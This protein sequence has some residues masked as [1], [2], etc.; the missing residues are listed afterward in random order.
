MTN[1]VF[2]WPNF[3]RITSVSV[4]FEKRFFKQLTVNDF[5]SVFSSPV[6]KIPGLNFPLSGSGI[7]FSKLFKRHLSKPIKWVLKVSISLTLNIQI[8]C[9]LGFCSYFLQ[10]NLQKVVHEMLVKSLKVSFVVKKVVVLFTQKKSLKK[11]KVL[12][13]FLFS[14]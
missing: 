11:N 8:F 5:Y 7:T 2:L 12:T 3:F 9:T 6:F 4:S 1:L 14:S 13:V 10:T